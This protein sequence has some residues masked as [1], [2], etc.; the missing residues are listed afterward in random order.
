MGLRFESL[1]NSLDPPLTSDKKPY[2][3]A[4]FKELV[5]E[6]YL[7]SKHSNTSYKDTEDLTPLE[8]SYILEFITDELQRKK[9]AYEKMKQEQD[10]RRR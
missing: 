3:P 2:G 6:R 5:K 9:E 10:A 7:I 1:L 4:R 8:R